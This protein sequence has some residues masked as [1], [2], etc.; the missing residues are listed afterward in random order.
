MTAARVTVDAEDVEGVELH[1]GDLIVDPIDGRTVH[2]IDT[3]TGWRYVGRDG[4]DHA[5]RAHG[6]AW[7]ATIAD[8]H[9]YHRIV[10]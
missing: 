10:I 5:R 2:R 8:H 6:T 7:A 1:E 4:D 9:H 3:F